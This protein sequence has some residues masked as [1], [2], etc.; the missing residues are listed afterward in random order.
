M[1][2]SHFLYG[3]LATN[4]NPSTTSGPPHSV[5]LIRKGN[6]MEIKFRGA[7]ILPFPN[8]DAGWVY[9]NYIKIMDRV[10]NEVHLIVTEDASY[11]DVDGEWM[12][13]GATEVHPDS[14]GMFIG[15]KDKKGVEIYEK[16]LIKRVYGK[17]IH[18]VTLQP[19]GFSFNSVSSSDK[20]NRRYYPAD[21]IDITM[22]EIIGNTTD[23]PELLKG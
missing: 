17:A 1:M 20:C 4:A 15:L 18:V 21:F 2:Y 19:G 22:W 14:V 23:N 10:G 6:N 11:E 7:A 12:L 13:A 5:S 3:Y 8:K 16:D 9:G